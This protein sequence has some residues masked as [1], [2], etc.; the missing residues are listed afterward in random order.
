MASWLPIP[1]KS[2]KQFPKTNRSQTGQIRFANNTESTQA[3]KKK[4]TSNTRYSAEELE[5]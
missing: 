4:D 1:T 3:A 2:E 5:P